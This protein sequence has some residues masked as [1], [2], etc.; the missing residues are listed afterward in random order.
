[1]P[2]A[3]RTTPEAERYERHKAG[4]LERQNAQSAAGRDIGPIPAVAKPRRRA[5]CKRS[6][7][8]FCR[9]YLSQTFPL[10]FSPDHL[11]VIGKAETAVLAGG[12]FANAMPR[13]SG[14]TTI[15]ESACL[16][17]LIYGHRSFV[18][19]IGA[20]EASA[21]RSLESIKV[22][23][24][25]NEL[26]HADF[27]EV[28]Y[29]IQRLERI[30]H[31]CRG[32]TCL[33]EPTYLA[34]QSDVLTLPTVPQ[35]HAAGATVRVAGLTGSIRGMKHKRPDGTS[36]RPD[37][38][39][40]D[41]P[42]TDESARSA[43]QCA[44]RERVLSGAVLGLAGP[45][46]K[47][48]GIMPC[49][50]IAPGDVAD[51][52]LNPTLHPQWHGERTKLLYGLPE[53]ADLWDRYAQIRADSLR[54]GNGG[55]EATEFYRANR[56]EMDRGAA[57][58]WPQRHHPDEASAV[59]HAMNLRIDDPRAFAAEYQNEP[60]PEVEE[61]R[62]Q[63]VADQVAARI[64]RHARGLAPAGAA[65]LTTMID[66]QQDLLYW[67]V[68]GWHDDFTG[69]VVDYGAWPEQ[70]RAYFT[71]REA[72]PTI[73]AATGIASLEGSLFA[74]LTKLVD[75]LLGKAWA[76]DGGGDLRVERLM[77]DANWGESTDVVYRWARQSSHSALILPS[78]GK[79]IGAS[80]NPMSEWPTKPGE[81]R[82]LNWVSPPPKPGRVRYLLY[83]TN[84]WKSFVAGRLVIPPGERGGLDLFGDSPHTHR[85]F[86][87]H[88]CAE[89]RVRTSGRGREV[90]EWKIRPHRPDNHWWDCL[91]GC[92]VAASYQGCQPGGQA[93]QA[94]QSR[95]R[96]SWAEMQRK[97]REG[98]PA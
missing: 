57:P 5:A 66:V 52:L 27:P 51:R 91:T 11:K 16:W 43:S 3:R 94:R 1:M 14:K 6:L 7:L 90:D 77:V 45:G 81:R 41:D 93:A 44:Y 28:C 75:L 65:R 4:A 83:D 21:L 49:T 46:K 86:A 42:Q 56:A 82:G 53:R 85:L 34:W 20:D 74:A 2:A 97:R 79:A 76:V 55:R 68:C 78:H 95:P 50:V 54:A 32:Q 33:G 96:V 58:A 64:N 89:Y 8:K 71:L 62:G 30:S 63:L 84:W 35:S 18:V 25:T 37:L 9:T 12:L 47:I 72:R 38:V 88:L 67:C 13:G 26:L 87:D 19:L 70:G 61:D 73:S 23:L 59:Q 29:P 10:P 36:I 80:G 31:R 48:S 39:V 60:L 40:I 24:E 17:A 98:R 15:A 22:E 92:A 69:S